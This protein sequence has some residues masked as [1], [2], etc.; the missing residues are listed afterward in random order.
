M[1]Y[2]GIFRIGAIA[3]LLSLLVMASPTSPALAAED[4]YLDPDEGG[5]GDQIDIAG[6]GFEESYYNSE[7]D[8]Y[9]SYVDIYFS[10]DEADEGDD[11]DDDV[12]NYERVKSGV[13]VD[14][15]GEFDTYF[16]V[17]DELTDGD[18][19]EVVSSGTYYVYV[20]Y[21]DYSNI[22][23]V[24][25]FTVIAAGIGLDPDNGPVGTEV[26]LSGIDFTDYEDITIEFDDDE[27]DIESGDDETDSYGEFE[28]TIIIPEST[29]GEHT[30]TVTDE[31]GVEAE[32]EFTVEP[33]ITVT[34]DEGAPGD[35]VTVDGTGFGEDVDVTIEFDGDE[36]AED[37]SD[38]DGSFAVTFTLPAKGPGTY[39]IRAE[40]EDGNE[41]DVGFDIT[42]EINLSRTT[43]NVGSEVAVSGSGF[44]PNAMVTVTYASEPVVVATTTADANGK[45]SATFTVPKSKYGQHTITAS[46]SAGITAT[47]MFTMESTPPQAPLPLIPQEGTK[48][49]SQA[50][51][52]WDDATDP[53]GVSYTLQ[54]AADESFTDIVLEKT[55][56]AE[57]EYTLTEEEK[58]EPTSNEAPYY[59]RVRAVDGAENASDW[60]TPGPFYVRSTFFKG[61]IRYAVIGLSVGLLLLI[62]YLLRRRTA[63]PVEEENRPPC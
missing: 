43:G 8:Y 53:S 56:L 63:H 54:I 12:E 2:K 47:T 28:C 31:S 48:A 33:Q 29:A 26:E 49:D 58:L 60:T 20:T 38:D 59:W 3:V 7:T 9:Y 42:L 30:I 39:E 34:P 23:A 57:S 51:F 22:E 5:I 10:S 62:I 44:T 32:A 27:V 6:E 41:D 13:Y 14:N 37:A 11:I 35:T 40:D 1:R 15:Y 24:A 16:Y 45:F 46:D 4:I 21:E 19:D 18:E 36:V 55:E 17:P 50:Y 61:W 25:E 52:D